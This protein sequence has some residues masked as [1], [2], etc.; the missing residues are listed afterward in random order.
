MKNKYKSYKDN[1]MKAMYIRVKNLFSNNNRGF[2]KLKKGSN[3]N[4]P[5]IGEKIPRSF[6]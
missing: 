3:S 5:V 2:N 1:K 6:K 4:K